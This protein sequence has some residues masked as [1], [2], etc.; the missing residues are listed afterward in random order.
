MSRRFPAARHSN[1]VAEYWK[2]EGNMSGDSGLMLRESLRTL[3]K[4]KPALKT[5]A[6]RAAFREG[7]RHWQHYYGER[8][9]ET[10]AGRF[11]AKKIAAG[12]KAA[13]VLCRFAPSVFIAHAA[14]LSFRT[15]R[16]LARAIPSSLGRGPSPTVGRRPRRRI[17]E[18]SA[19]SRFGLGRSANG[20]D[21]HPNASPSR[22]SFC[23]TIASPTSTRIRGIWPCLPE[24]FASRC[25]CSPRR[26]SACP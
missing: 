5:A 26:A 18:R 16:A 9:W 17:R 21:A 1:V 15:S 7:I 19:P 6:E 13:F 4:Q 25:E 8:Q 12:F 24:T 22:P 14:T 3:R 10:V 11:K 2:H 20:A 23:S